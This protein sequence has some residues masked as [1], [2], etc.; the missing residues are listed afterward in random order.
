MPS[1]LITAIKRMTEMDTTRATPRPWELCERGAYTDFEGNSRVIIGDNMRIAVVQ[2]DGRQET[3]ANAALII[4]AINAHDDMLAALRECA[5]FFERHMGALYGPG[6]DIPMAAG[7]EL[8]LRKIA[9][10]LKRVEG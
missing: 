3:E 9:D 5:G 2:T 6:H 4:R 1:H 8:V 7:A 10:A